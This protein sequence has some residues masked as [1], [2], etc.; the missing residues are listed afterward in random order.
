[1]NTHTKK[2]NHSQKVLN[3]LQV[4][5]CRMEID[6]THTLDVRDGAHQHIGKWVLVSVIGTSVSEYICERVWVWRFWAHI[7]M[8]YEY[9][10]RCE[11]FR[12]R[13]FKQN[14]KKRNSV[15]FES[16]NASLNDWYVCL[17]HNLY[18]F[19]LLISVVGLHTH[20]HTLSAHS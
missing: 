15:S 18:I 8:R 17:I 1:M 19:F 11:R 12:W 6:R 9:V 2:N 16:V 5:C 10:S 3:W 14:N 7:H 20:T 13:T 4:C